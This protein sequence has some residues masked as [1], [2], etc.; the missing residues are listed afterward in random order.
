MLHA[1]S[2]LLR[3]VETSFAEGRPDITA[4]LQAVTIRLIC[5]V[6]GSTI[7]WAKNRIDPILRR[8]VRDHFK[9]YIF[10]EQLRLD[11]PTGTDKNNKVSLHRASDAYYYLEFLGEILQAGFRLISQV[12]F[13]I[14]QP[15]GG[16]TLTLLSLVAPFFAWRLNEDLWNQAYVIYAS[17]FHYLRLHAL[18]LFV[19]DEYREETISANIKPWIYAEY[20]KAREELGDISDRHP[21]SRSKYEG[22]PIVDIVARLSTDLP[23][24]YWAA[25]VIFQPANFSITSFAILQQHAEALRATIQG[26]LYQYSELSEC[27]SNIGKLY[28][29]KEVENKIVDGEAAYPNSTLSTEKGMEVEFKNVSFAYPGAKSND[30][31]IK[32]ISFKIP[33]GHLVVIVGANGSGKS[34]LIKLVSRLYD[35]DS[36][37]ILIDGLPIKDYRLSDFRNAQALLTQDHT[38]YPLTLAE[39]IGLGD[40]NRINDMARILQ[41]VECGGASDVINKLTDGL[42]TTLSPVQTAEGYRLDKEEHKKLQSI[43]EELEQ[44]ADVSGGEKQRLVAA[45]TFMRF[46]SGKIRFAAADEP[47]SALD[48]KAEYRLFQ[49][50][51]DSR[52]GKTLIFVTHRFGHLTKHA[53]LVICMKDGEIVEAGTHK[54]LIARDGEYSE[55]Y[56]VQAQAFEDI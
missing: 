55:L 20:R 3:A 46:F 37:E 54:Q 52:D 39:N 28:Q 12:I 51:R 11:L 1:S 29:I 38:L 45:R 23:M 7:C 35:V 4:I 53:D 31:A 5:N 22:T 24:F 56:N 49:R 34:T 18:R 50:L 27:V 26:L 13:T 6:F 33:A 47:S 19:S 15:T 10:R 25:S 43:L 32:D 8:R 42:Q 41:A 17:N 30:S 14:S 16:I 36:G 44:Q 40:P 2:R 21:Q 48:P 9:E